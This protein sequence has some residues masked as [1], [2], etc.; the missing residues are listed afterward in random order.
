MKLL[1]LTRILQVSCSDWLRNTLAI[2][3][4][5]RLPSANTV[6][7]LFAYQYDHNYLLSTSEFRS[8]CAIN[9]IVRGN[10][11]L[12]IG[13]YKQRLRHLTHEMFDGWIHTGRIIGA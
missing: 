11:I 4:P 13:V 9:T 6:N 3:Y 7:H 5:Q 10:H 1:L 12:L 8:L 2:T